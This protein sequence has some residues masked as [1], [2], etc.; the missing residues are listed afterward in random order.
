M[1]NKKNSADDVMKDFETMLKVDPSQDLPTSNI[2]AEALNA[3]HVLHKTAQSLSEHH[4]KNSLSYMENRFLGYS[5]A[6]DEKINIMYW[7]QG[8]E[9][10]LSGKY[11]VRLSEKPVSGILTLHSLANQSNELV[12]VTATDEESDKLIADCLLGYQIQTYRGQFVELSKADSLATIAKIETE[13]DPEPKYLTQT[14]LVKHF[15]KRLEINPTY[16]HKTLV[17]LP[18]GVLQQIEHE[19]REGSK[20]S[21]QDPSLKLTFKLKKSPVISQDEVDKLLAFVKE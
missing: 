2:F 18:V 11:L 3:Y 17:K 13:T 20:N 1:S 14:V 9:I 4:F 5:I 19:W 8:I 10:D 12:Q 15:G 21:K 6:S 16:T 7:S